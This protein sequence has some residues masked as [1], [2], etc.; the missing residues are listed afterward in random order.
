MRILTGGESHGSELTAIIEGVP[1][2]LSLLAKD[3]NVELARRQ[4]GYGRG[5]RMKIEK[6]QVCF[7]S[8]VRHGAT[9]GAPLTMVIK[10]KD[11]QNW[12]TIMSSDP[13]SK[14][15]SELRRLHHPR[16][17]HADLVGGQ[18]YRHRDL[19]N[20]LE[21]S[22]ARETTYTGCYWGGCQKDLNA[23]RNFCSRSC[24]KPRWYR[25]F[26]S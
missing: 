26:S 25:S 4:A 10:N 23:V 13:V 11:F 12:Q 20:V 24:C 5:D 17:G 2:G 21:R 7:T 8:G 14:E 22:S 6:D 1:A 9:T 3:I 15:D 16:A 18:K 19:R